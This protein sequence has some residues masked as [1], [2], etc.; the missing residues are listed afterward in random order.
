MPLDSK[1]DGEPS[2]PGRPPIESQIAEAA[3]ETRVAH[4]LAD[5][6]DAVPWPEL[7]GRLNR[8]EDALAT[9]AGDDQLDPG[10]SSVLRDLHDQL[11]SHLVA[12]AGLKAV[13]VSPAAIVDVLR[14]AADATD[15]GLETVSRRGPGL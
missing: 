4:E 11:T 9:I 3:R 13:E 2:G 7:E 1:A 14:R 10:V 8:I 12:A 5:R 6:E 15:R